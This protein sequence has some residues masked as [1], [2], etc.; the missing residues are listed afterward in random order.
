MPDRS[1]QPELAAYGPHR[2]P[3][4][5]PSLRQSQAYCR[6]LAASHYENFTVASWLLPKDLRQHFA[7]V[8]AYCRWA[9]DLAD[10]VGNAQQSL[11]LLDW[12]AGELER[13]Y[14][15][16]AE[17]PVFIA[18]LKTI[19]EFE[20]PQEPF[21]DLL[22]AFRQDQTQTS[23]DTF[24]E[25]LAYCRHSANPVGSL[26]LYLGRCSNAMT[27]PLS[28]SIC[29]GL[30]LANHWQDVARDFAKGRIYLPRE[31]C[32]RFQVTDDMLA[33]N[34]ASLEFTRLMEFEVE[35]A[36]AL[37][38]AGWPLVTLVPQRLKIAIRLF[39]LGGLETLAAIRQQDYDVLA[40]RPTLSKWRKLQLL[41]MAWRGFRPP[42]AKAVSV[43]P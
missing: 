16:E 39:L 4:D 20:I 6:R 22:I 2:D 24:D 40:H 28:D 23:Y 17:H 1:F 9:D 12:W 26:V 43:K 11:L 19:R 38:N 35:R 31:D 36:A 25:L 15:G 18:L 21:R 42:V 32:D 30:Q 37:L 13:C 14:A 34:V 41:W 7:N 27:V 8:Y 29:T 5:V 3:G 33:D 10:E